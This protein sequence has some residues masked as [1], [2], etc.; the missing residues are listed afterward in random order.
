[1]LHNIYIDILDNNIQQWDNVVL[2]DLD[3]TLLK[4]SLLVELINFLI[5]K[6]DILD[7]SVE[8]SFTEIKND[9]EKRNIFYKEYANK[10]FIEFIEMIKWMEYELLD[11]IAYEVVEEYYKKI[12][13]TVLRY[14]QEL[15]R[16]WFKIILISNSSQD[17]LDFFVSKYNFNCWLWTILETSEDFIDNEDTIEVFTWNYLTI[18]NEDNKLDLVKYIKEKNCNIVSFWDSLEDLPLFEYSNFSYV[19]NPWSKLYNEIKDKSNVLVTIEKKDISF[20][21][22][23]NIRENIDISFF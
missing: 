22:D 21:L 15:Q 3:G 17:I 19:V 18:S 5:E 8:D 2:C 7:L 11:T 23:K 1:M 16:E 12:H 20:T 6:W 4:T 9:Y 13:F 14:L 10:V